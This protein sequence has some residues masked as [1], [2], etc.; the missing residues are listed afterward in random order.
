MRCPEH[1]KLEKVKEASQTIGEFLDWLKTTR[2]TQLS[3]LHKH[4]ELCGRI[5]KWGEG[6]DC[7]LTEEHYQPDYTSTH[8]LL[9]EYFGIDLQKLEQ[10]KQAMLDELRKA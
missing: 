3:K 6:K 10:E 7:G 1:E 9:A 4:D 5:Y 8:N 2:G